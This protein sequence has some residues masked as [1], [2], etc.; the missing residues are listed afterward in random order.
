[1]TETHWELLPQRRL[2]G[3]HSSSAGEHGIQINWS[4]I[5]LN[6]IVVYECLCVFVCARVCVHSCM[7]YICVPVWMHVGEC[8]FV[9]MC[10]QMFVTVCVCV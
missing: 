8:L 6:R 2:F 10:M 5:T 4:F 9:C 1:M 3:G 7:R